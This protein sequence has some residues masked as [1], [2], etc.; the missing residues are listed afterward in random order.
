MSKRSGSILKVSVLAALKG[1]SDEDEEEEAWWSYPYWYEDERAPQS[2][3]GTES[4]G[5]F[6]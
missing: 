3:S 2:K 4:D 5:H 6:L 1:W